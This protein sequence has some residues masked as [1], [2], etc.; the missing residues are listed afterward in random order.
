MNWNQVRRDVG[1]GT[2][3]PPATTPDVRQLEILPELKIR[4]P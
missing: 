4:Y 2:P 1:F 3:E